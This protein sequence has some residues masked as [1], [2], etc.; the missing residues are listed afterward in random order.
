MSEFLQLEKST[1][2]QI[3]VHVIC[4]KEIMQACLKKKMFSIFLWEENSLE[5]FCLRNTNL[6]DSFF[7][8]LHKTVSDSRRKSGSTSL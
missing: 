5:M 4:E 3:Q 2:E 8:V 7:K 1:P 6:F